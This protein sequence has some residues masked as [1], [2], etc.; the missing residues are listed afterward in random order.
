MTE[1]W[2]PHVSILNKVSSLLCFCVC[3]VL[4]LV[5]LGFFGGVFFGF[6]L[7]SMS[8]KG[9]GFR[10]VSLWK[11]AFQVRSFLGF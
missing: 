4:I 6:L 11:C 2:S 5:F 1:M 10:F 3:E 7:L 9:K 8:G